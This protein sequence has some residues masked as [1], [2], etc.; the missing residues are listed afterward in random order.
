M[1]DKSRFKLTLFNLR[2]AISFAL[3]CAAAV[4]V[5]ADIITVTTIADS[6]PGSL[7]QALADAQA[8]TPFNSIR[9]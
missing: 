7:R 9:R 2:T 4:S 6:G 8:V 3:V 1:N 5:H